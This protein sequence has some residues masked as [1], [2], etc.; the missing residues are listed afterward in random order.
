MKLISKGTMIA[1]W[2]H[3]VWTS[4]AIAAPE[5][6]I[7]Q[8]TPASTAAPPPAAVGGDVIELKSG[9]VL[10]GT[11]I[12]AIPNG[13]ARMQLVTGEVATVPWQDVARIDRSS[14]SPAI[15]P[16]AA[17][18]A[19]DEK[20][21]VHIEGSDDAQLQRDTGDRRHWDNVCSAPC[22][23]FVS[24]RYTYR[25]GGPGIR[26]S[27]PFGL[28]APDGSRETLTVDEA[29]KP[30]FVLG[31][32]GV[33]LGSVVMSV[34]LVVVLL[35]A[36]VDATDS[37]FNSTPDNGNGEAIGWTVAG[38]GLAALVGGIVLIATNARSGV[39]Q[40]PAGGSAA[41]PAPLASGTL[42]PWRFPTHEA[43]AD[44]NLV[45]RA[46]SVPIFSARF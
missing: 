9:G 14:S 11:L 28:T 42:P 2:T 1:A 22:D 5:T 15:P 46:T 25:I 26:N 43:R 27:G 16:P 40:A 44:E 20:V 29:S 4:V 30:S 8:T 3:V 35:N 23:Q 33:S 7:A 18:A 39:Q 34:G 12:D 45:P 24:A 37:A 10:R 41:R 6:A 19:Q 31:I 17:P 21:Y 38:V 32:V 13:H 36:A